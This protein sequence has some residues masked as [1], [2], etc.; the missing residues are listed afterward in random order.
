MIS[1]LKDEEIL[2]FL[3]TSE[4][5]G[6]YSPEELKYLLIKWRF[7]YR[8]LNGRLDRIKD[9]SEGDIRNLKTSIDSL[10]K[11]VNDLLI[12]NA[13]KDNLIDS[14]KNRKLTWKERFSGEIITKVEDT[15]K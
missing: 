9:D 14:M 13:D 8:M 10:N 1:E 2:D 5:D 15:K 3:M 7:F 11:S 4:F 6:D 12:K